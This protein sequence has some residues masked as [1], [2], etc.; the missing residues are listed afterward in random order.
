[1]LINEYYL[2]PQYYEADARIAYKTTIG[3]PK[4]VPTT[5]QSEDWIIDYWF[6]KGKRPMSTQASAE[7]IP[8]ETGTH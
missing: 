3:H 4:A 5:Y 2:V 1:V 7:K 6:P 8:A